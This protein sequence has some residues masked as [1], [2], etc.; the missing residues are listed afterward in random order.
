MKPLHAVALGLAVIAI[1]AR[2]GDY[3]LLADPAGWLL[4][5]A[6]LKLLTD[7]VDLPLAGLLWTVGLLALAASAALSVPPV[8]DWFE[9]AD[10]A[11]G[12]AVDAP[13]LAF[14]GLLCHSLV[15]G[16]RAAKEIAAY[17]W[18]QW[19]SIGFIVAVAAPVV[20]IGGGVEG[21]R[22]PAALVTALAQLSLFVLCL[23]YSGRE[24]AGA[25]AEDPA[26]AD[27]HPP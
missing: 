24:W 1:Y 14:C 13:A 26:G 6:G 21:L 15:P 9:D 20:V 3:D 18:L 22:G 27:P 5:L 4:V 2:A 11:L 12:W 19:T 23:M 7:R 17:A 25:S 10:P 16:A 8:R